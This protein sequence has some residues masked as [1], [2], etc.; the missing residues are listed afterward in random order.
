M[1]RPSKGRIAGRA[2][3]ALG[4]YRLLALRATARH[5]AI[6]DLPARE[7][8][9]G[10]GGELLLTGLRAV[11]GEL[12]QHTGILRRDE[13]REVLVRGMPRDFDRGEDLHGRGDGRGQKA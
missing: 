11:T 6:L 3:A 12:I 9:E 8:L 10:T 4:R 5:H 2:S 7:I 1:R 13:H